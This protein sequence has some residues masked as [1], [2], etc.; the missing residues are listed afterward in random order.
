MRLVQIPHIELFRVL[1][2]GKRAYCFPVKKLGWNMPEKTGI[3][4]FYTNVPAFLLVRPCNFQLKSFS[5]FRLPRYAK[6]ANPATVA[7]QIVTMI[8]SLPD[9]KKL[10][11]SENSCFCPADMRYSGS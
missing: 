7:P 8:F 5:I 2:A 11:I 10:T 4:Y 9:V 1:M 6:R 3:T